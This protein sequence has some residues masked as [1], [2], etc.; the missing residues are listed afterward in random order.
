MWMLLAVLL[1]A[2]SV[3]ARS[4]NP[5]DNLPEEVILHAPFSAFY[6]DTGLALDSALLT[7]KTL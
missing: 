7:I 2:A 6:N 3:A 1:F 4:S 5:F